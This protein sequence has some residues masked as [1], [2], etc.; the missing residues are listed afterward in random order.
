MRFRLTP[1]LLALAGAAVVLYLG[2]PTEDIYWSDFNTEAWPA[3][4]K[5]IHGDVTG[6]LA[7]S[8]IAYGGSMLLRAPAAALSTDEPTVYRLGVIPCLIALALLAAHLGARAR[9]A[10]PDTRWWVLVIALAGASP[11]AWKAV[12]YGHPEELLTTALAIAAILVALDGRAI[13]AGLLLGAAMASKQWAILALFPTALALPKH[14]SKMLA[15]AAGTAVA[16][17]APIVLAD[18]GAYLTAQQGAISSAQWFR[19]R[20]LWWPFG[21]PSTDPEAPA[22]ATVTPDWLSTV[23]KP[24]I[25]ALSVPLAAFAARRPR[26]DA[27]LLFA[28]LMLLRCALDPWN[29]IYYHLPLVVALVA[30]EVLDG[31]RIPLLALAAT[32]ATWLTFETYDAAYSTGPWIAYLAWTIPLGAYLAHRL[33]RSAPATLLR[34]CAGP[35]SAARRSSPSTSTT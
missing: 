14:H 1:W 6:F 4:E 15:T 3:F 26:T 17:L 11:L 13:L 20:Q 30:W 31:R 9:R 8:P 5:L 16:L 23:A 12:W 35:S 22:G 24:L 7:A 21:I 10:H 2:A 32:G 33:Y 34:P 28:L 29:S 19:P 27:M 18:P 25:V